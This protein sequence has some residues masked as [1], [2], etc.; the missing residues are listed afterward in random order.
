MAD[1]GDQPEAEA[2]ARSSSLTWTFG[3]GSHVVHMYTW[4]RLGM[5]GGDFENRMQHNNVNILS[6]QNLN[7]INPDFESVL[8]TKNPLTV[9]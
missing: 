6:Y 8:S 2:F 4:T 9:V 1:D 7:L 5:A 3:R